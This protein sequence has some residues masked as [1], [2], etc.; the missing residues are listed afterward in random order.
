MGWYKNYLENQKKKQ[1][2][3]LHKIYTDYTDRQL[4]ELIAYSLRGLGIGI[5]LLFIWYLLFFR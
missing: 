4:L 1:K 5:A 2:I 3:K